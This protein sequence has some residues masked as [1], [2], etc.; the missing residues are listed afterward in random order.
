MKQFKFLLASLTLLFAGGAWA[1][2][3]VTSTYLNNADFSQG[4]PVTVGICTYAK[5]KS[6]NGT[7]YANLVEV[8][9]WT[10][11]SSAD[12]KAGGLFAIGGG[13]WLGGVGYTAPPTDSDGNTGVN[14]LGVVTCWSASVQYTQVVKTPILAGTYTLVLAA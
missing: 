8:E 14:V 13:A 5:D 9:G 2:T 12:G 11:V 7:N 6:D 4:T 10:A 3:D 1:Q